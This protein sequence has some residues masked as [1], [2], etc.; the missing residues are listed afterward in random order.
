M[1]KKTWG[2]FNQS[3]FESSLS[4]AFLKHLSFGVKDLITDVDLVIL[5]W[6]ETQEDFS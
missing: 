6:T 4:E 5:L 2:F 1:F 3:L